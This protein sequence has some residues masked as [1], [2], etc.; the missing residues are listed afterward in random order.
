M[1]PSAKSSLTKKPTALSSSL[2]VKLKNLPKSSIENRK[3]LNSIK[4]S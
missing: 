1:I 3:K 2:N 4:F